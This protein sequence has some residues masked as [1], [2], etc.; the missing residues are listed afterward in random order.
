M[1][2]EAEQVQGIV[3]D[4]C[5]QVSDDEA[6][7]A[8]YVVQSPSTR[9]KLANLFVDMPAFDLELLF[10]DEVDPEAS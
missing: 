8:E 3:D 2:V 4:Y 6:D 5:Q 10:E 1:V 9:C 7:D